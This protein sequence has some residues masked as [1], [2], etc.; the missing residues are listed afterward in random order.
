MSGL[1]LFPQVHRKP[2]GESLRDP[3][4]LRVEDPNEDAGGRIGLFAARR[5]DQICK[6]YGEPRRST[7]FPLPDQQ[8]DAR[9][10][11]LRLLLRVGAR[12]QLV[13]MGR[14]VGLRANPLGLDW[15]SGKNQMSEE[16]EERA[17]HKHPR[18][19]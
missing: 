15:P 12:P 6:P 17:G 8:R 4:N 3:Q 9:P 19:L 7:G 13:P 14:R 1:T 16:E 2:Y 10:D 5:R 18:R 11:L